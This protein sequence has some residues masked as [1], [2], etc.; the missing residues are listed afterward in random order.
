MARMTE[1]EANR[2]DE[3]LTKTTP[4]FTSG[5]QGVFA[6]QR[7]MVVVLDSVTS[8]YLTSQMIA[9]KKNPADIISDMVRREMKS[10]IS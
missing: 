7:D 5:E 2:L 10:A 4:T 6:R 1:E 9:T 8:R 3:E